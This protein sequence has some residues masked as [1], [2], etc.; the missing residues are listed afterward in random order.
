MSAPSLAGFLDDRTSGAVELAE[1][2]IGILESAERSGRSPG[3]VRRL[4][5]RLSRAHPAMGAVWNAVRSTDRRA[6]LRELR[7][8]VAAAARHARCLIPQGAHVVTISYSSTVVAV[9]GRHDLTVT[10]AQSLPGG[11]GQ[12]TARLLRRQGAR[13]RVVPDTLMCES[14]AAAHLALVGADAVT[15]RLVVNKVGTRMLALAARDARRPCYVVADRSK[16]VPT[17]WPVPVYRPSQPFEATPR[18]LF[19]V[20]VGEDG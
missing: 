3:Q 13:V 20:I 5:N 6:F 11:E 19:G 7:L 12:K 8:G 9:L 14:L 4:A 2:A 15:P 1:R 10:I 18:R 17:S 16:W